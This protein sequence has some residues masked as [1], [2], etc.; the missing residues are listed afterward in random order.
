METSSREK[1][2][3]LRDLNVLLPVSDIAT[4]EEILPLAVKLLGHSD[5]LYVSLVGVTHV[6]SETSLSEGAE[7]AQRLRN[8]LDH[9][10]DEDPRAKRL[11]ASLVSHQPWGDIVSLID[12]RADDH[13]LLLLPWQSGATYFQ[14]EL[15]KVLSDSP[16][17]IV[18]AQPAVPAREIKRILLPVRGG[19]FA[20]LSLQ[21][22][23]RLA[24]AC[25]AEITLLRVLSSD[26]DPMSQILRERFTGLSD[27]FPEITTELQIVA[28]VGAAILREVKTHQ[29]IILGASAVAEAPIGLVATLILQRK[30]I[31]TLVVKTKEPF[32]MPASI[33][34]RASLPVLVRVEKWFAENTFH[35]R[36]FSDISRLIDLKQQQ[37][38][39]ISLGLPTHNDEATIGN[40]I[41]TIKSSLVDDA[42]LLDEIILLDGNSVD[43]TRKIAAQLGVT[44]YIHQET[45]SGLGRF[46]GKGE[47][48]WKGLYLLK[49]DLIVWLDTDII[50]PHPRLV[51]GILGPLLSNSEIQYVKGFDQQPSADGESRLEDRE[52]VTELL[53]RP[54]INLFFPELS[55]V[56]Q[57][58]SGIFGG[59]RSS[60]ERMPFYSGF[61]VEMGLLLSVLNQFELKAIAQVDLEEVTHRNRELRAPGKM[62][63]SILQVFAQ[64]LQQSGALD[65]SAPIERTM[66]MLRVEDERVHLEEFDVHEQRRPPMIEVREY[67]GRHMLKRMTQP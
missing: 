17:D 16:C 12:Q 64:Q 22:A 5:G 31:T 10:A 42:P 35:N 26:D 47:A 13:D 52:L 57:P 25:N 51:C 18:I 41:R 36:E 7:R 59:R 60:L 65:S 53:V 3:V 40:I 30:D 21:L 14:A 23:V 66:R 55:G 28:D 29:A 8:D 63:F 24:R 33:P 44:P 6:L 20:N 67:R 15:A 58:L 45:L 43:D 46:R 56:V 37:G 2:R 48:L 34:A 61:G 1:K 54:M 38:L 4:A 49:G 39:R 62:A 11:P 27:A 32:H 19:P 9:L 50:N